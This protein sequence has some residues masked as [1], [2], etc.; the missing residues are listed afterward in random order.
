MS[1]REFKEMLN[2]IL[3]LTP[4]QKRRL[5]LG[6]QKSVK[7]DELP[8]PV[9]QR[10]AELDRLRVCTHCGSSGVVRYGKSAGLCRFRCRSASCGRT[11]HAQTGTHLAGLQA[12]VE[13]VGIRRVFARSADAASVGRAM[14][15]RLPDRILVAASLAW[16]AVERLKT[17]RNRGDRTRPIF[18][19]AA[20]EIVP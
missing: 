19:R 16:Q 15:D 13:V 1:P 8:G 11:F 4:A 5:M 10:E 7:S 14:R 6:V 17:Q 12:Q 18:W 20:R 2:Q 9:R 3:R